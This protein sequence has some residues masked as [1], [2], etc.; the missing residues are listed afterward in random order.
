MPTRCVDAPCRCSPHA[1]S[2]GGVETTLERRARYPAE[3]GIPE[4]L[5]RVS[6]GCE[7]AEDLWHDLMQAL[8]A[9]RG[10]A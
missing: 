7:H 8:E 1:T 2:L 3:R 5:L 10:S 6:V 9:T 4:D